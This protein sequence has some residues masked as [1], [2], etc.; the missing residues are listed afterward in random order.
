[1]FAERNENNMWS[2]HIKGITL[3]MMIIG[4]VELIEYGYS[5]VLMD[6]D[7]KE[8]NMPLL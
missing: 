4:E 2:E 1:M 7:I 6:F 3:E 5:E 8:N